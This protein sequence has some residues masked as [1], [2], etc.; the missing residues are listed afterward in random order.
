[1]RWNEES[2]EFGVP[3]MIASID[4]KKGAGTHASLSPFDL[5]N[6]LVAAGPDFK[7]GFVDEMARGNI[8]VA[9]SVLYLLGLA[10][11]T[12]MDGRI[13]S[14]ALTVDAPPPPAPLAKTN[15][16]RHDLPIFS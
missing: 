11:S 7:K 14:E 5:H 1:M 12:P 9:P 16:A 4:G 8:D 2:N 13:L 6:T 3:G 10:P 15:E